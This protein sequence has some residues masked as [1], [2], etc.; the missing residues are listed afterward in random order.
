[1]SAPKYITESEVSF[2]TGISAGT[3][4]NW[5]WQR[6]GIPFLKIGRLVRYELKQVI[7]YIEDHQAPLQND[8]RPKS[9]QSETRQPAIGV[10]EELS[11]QSL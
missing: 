8:R 6:K 5:R 9:A 1:M 7:D 2:L 10:G 3:L 4:R 11:N